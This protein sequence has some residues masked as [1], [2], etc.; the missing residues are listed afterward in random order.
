MATGLLAT[1]LLV[2]VAV[3]ILARVNNGELEHCDVD[4]QECYPPGSGQSIIEA[5][6]DSLKELNK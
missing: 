5:M 3:T 1:L 4:S 6:H 2:T